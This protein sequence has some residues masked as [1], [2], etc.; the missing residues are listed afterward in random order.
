MNCPF[1]TAQLTTFT[2]ACPF[3][4]RE[5]PPYIS[6]R[7]ALYVALHEEEEAL[8]SFTSDMTRITEVLSRRWHSLS[9]VLEKEITAGIAE[10][11]Q[12]PASAAAKDPGPAATTHTSPVTTDV[13]DQ[14]SPAAGPPPQADG[15]AVSLPELFAD[16]PA[17]QQPPGPTPPE[18]EQPQAP[19]EPTPHPNAGDQRTVLSELLIGQRWLLILGVIAVLTGVGY[20]LKYSIDHGWVNP[21]LRVGACY[22]FGLAF[23]AIG[24]RLRQ[25]DY[26]KYGLCLTALGIVLFYCSTYAG[27]GLYGIFGQVP[28]FILMVLTAALAI[29]LAIRYDSQATAILGILAGYAVPLLLGSPGHDAAVRLPYIVVLGAGIT[30]VATR[31]GWI[32]LRALGVALAYA[33]YAHWYAFAPA[34][35]VLLPFGCVSLLFLVFS[36]I[37]FAYAYTSKENVPVD[38]TSW[39]LN[40]LCALA[41]SYFLIRNVQSASVTALVPLAY[42]CLFAAMATLLARRGRQQIELFVVLVANAAVTLALVPPLLFSYHWLTIAWALIGLA[43]AWIGLRLGRPHFFWGGVTLLAFTYGKYLFWDYPMALTQASL[44]G[45][46]ASCGERLLTQALLLATLPGLTAMLRRLGRPLLDET[47]LE[48]TIKNFSLVFIILLWLA[49]T[50]ECRLLFQEY[51]P[52][53]R[54]GALSVLWAVYGAGLLVVGFRKGA[55]GLRLM[56]LAL[57]GLTWG[58]VFLV[59]TA[60]FSTPYRILVLL[61]LGLILIAASFLYHKFKGLVLDAK[62]NKDRTA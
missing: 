17:W 5:F 47:A 16:L 14:P 9:A 13:P 36:V 22:A 19:P 32:P 37:P 12:T 40:P 42:S 29:A 46:A 33:V 48:Q 44:A 52:A 24:E 57:L 53:A 31:Q 62:D 20:F 15:A 41:L 7:L 21:I 23:M 8:A 54:H 25:R 60:D 6:S 38:L 3:C 11:P 39:I 59:D 45:Y 58:K 61:L 51:L 18:P 10:A 30:L 1:C 2:A 4:H 55:K 34:G 27:Y 56:A 49:L 50:N 28:A 26:A 43:L 35:P